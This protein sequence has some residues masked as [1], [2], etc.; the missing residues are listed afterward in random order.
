MSDKAN[1]GYV[2]PENILNMMEF[3]FSGVHEKKPV[4]MRHAEVD[5]AFLAAKKA[6]AE[7]IE[8]ENAY[9][10][11]RGFVMELD[12]EKEVV[13]WREPK[14]HG[15]SLWG[16]QQ[17]LGVACRKE[18]MAKYAAEQDIAKLKAEHGIEDGGAK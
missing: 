2:I 8:A 16:R 17:A 12:H 1:G 3:G 7:L 10:V 13:R 11:S 5:K 15:G 14:E 6:C 4:A 18:Q 9:L